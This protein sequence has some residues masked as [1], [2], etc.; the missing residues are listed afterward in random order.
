MY[1]LEKAC[2]MVQPF[3]GMKITRKREPGSSYYEAVITE[4][5]G[6]DCR[7]VITD[8]DTL[9]SGI[10]PGYTWTF[11]HASIPDY[12]DFKKTKSGKASINV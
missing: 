3:V 9:H 5:D 12:Y 6:E 1:N 7:A 10:G 4:V 8:S 11:Q 2:T